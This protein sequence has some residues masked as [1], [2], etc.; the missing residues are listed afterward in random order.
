MPADELDTTQPTLDDALVD[1]DAAAIEAALYAL[2]D[3]G[4]LLQTLRRMPARRLALLAEVLGD[5]QF[6]DFLGEIEPADAADI[7]ER[8]TTA[9]AADVLEA[10]QPDEAADVAGEFAPGL[11]DRLLVAMEPQ[12]A[13]ELRDLL[14]YSPDTAG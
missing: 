13:A 2:D 6:G 14:A 8:L 7:L 3:D 11:V 5:E 10:M 1:R 9:D 12:E 4:Q